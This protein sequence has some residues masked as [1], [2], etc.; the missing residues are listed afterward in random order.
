MKNSI[1]TTLFI[2]ILVGITSCKQKTDEDSEVI[3]VLDCS[4]VKTG[5][6]KYANPAYGE[7]IIDRNETTSVEI[8]KSDD[9]K[10][11][12]DVEWI[13]DCE[14]ELH[15]TDTDNGDN[16]EVVTSTLRV[17][18]IDVMD[19]GYKCTSYTANGPQDFEMIR[20]DE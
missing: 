16:M 7:W 3:E 6:F 10:I 15:I 9:L 17:V 13:T 12:S 11:Y 4:S 1:T 2:L 18:I 14:Y 19:Y 20:I 5:K 8:S